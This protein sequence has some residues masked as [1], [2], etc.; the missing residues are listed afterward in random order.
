LISIVLP[1]IPF[2]A[3]GSGQTRLTWTICVGTL[4]FTHQPAPVRRRQ[5]PGLGE[6]SPPDTIPPQEQVPGVE[7]KC[8]RGTELGCL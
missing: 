1:T 7:G 6:P 2:L 8:V 5:R 3:Y 4:G